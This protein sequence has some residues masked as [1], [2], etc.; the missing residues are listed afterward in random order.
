MKKN[1][2]IV[3]GMTHD[4]H[5]TEGIYDTEVLRQ[6]IIGI[7]P[8]FILTE[9]PPNRFDNAM[10]EFLEFD[11]ITESRVNRFP[12]YVNVIFP[13]TKTMVFERIEK[14]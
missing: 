14:T 5:L 10:N 2:V 3:L 7:N 8:D 1:E 6:L 9:I 12:E 4:G 13:L 11:T